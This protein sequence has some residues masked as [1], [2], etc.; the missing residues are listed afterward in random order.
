MYWL[1][2]VKG[3]FCD[4]KSEP[5]ALQR[6][7]RQYLYFGTST[8]SKVSTLLRLEVG[9]VDAAAPFASVFVLL[10]RQRK[11]KCIPAAHDMRVKHHQVVSVEE[12]CQQLDAAAAAPQLSV[13]ALLNQ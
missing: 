11:V 6:L 10:Y 8:A 4:L 12:E 2:R 5:S 13:F 7:L 9:A 1:S 3:I